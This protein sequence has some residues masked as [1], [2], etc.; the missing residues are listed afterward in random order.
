[1]TGFIFCYREAVQHQKGTQTTV[2]AKRHTSVHSSL[3]DVDI[4]LARILL[5]VVLIAQPRDVPLLPHARQHLG[6]LASENQEIGSPRLQAAAQVCKSTGVRS[7]RGTCTVPWTQ[8]KS[9]GAT[10]E[11]LEKEAQSIDADALWLQEPRVQDK[12]WVQM[13][14]PL[15]G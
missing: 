10:C 4:P 3:L 1:M 15:D 2:S 9:E 13:G 8:G 7:I 6:W 14:G 5:R 12:D 11:R